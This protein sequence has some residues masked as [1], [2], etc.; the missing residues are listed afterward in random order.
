MNWVDMLPKLARFSPGRITVGVT[1]KTARV[2]LR[3]KRPNPLIWNGIPLNCIGSPSW[4]R[5]IWNHR[6]VICTEPKARCIG[7]KTLMHEPKLVVCTHCLVI[8]NAI[9]APNA[10]TSIS[11]QEPK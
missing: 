8:A 6:N 2:R 7:C 10:S 5:K 1:E 9:A 11:A 4:R 3:I